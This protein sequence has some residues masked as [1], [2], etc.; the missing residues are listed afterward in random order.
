MLKNLH[1]KVVTTVVLGSM[2]FCA[3]AMAA[4]NFYKRKLYA[5]KKKNSKWVIKK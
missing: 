5:I 1:S 3:S 2:V 4:L